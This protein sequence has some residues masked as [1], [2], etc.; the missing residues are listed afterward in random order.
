MFLKLLFILFVDGFLK[1]EL[2]VFLKD[3]RGGFLENLN[4]FFQRS[5]SLVSQF[6]L[7]RFMIA[8][9]AV[10]VSADVKILDDIVVNFSDVNVFSFVK[11][12]R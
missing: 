4:Q 3:L 10:V 1:T 9:D 5:G 8:N 7:K 11:K 6:P 2:I 12:K